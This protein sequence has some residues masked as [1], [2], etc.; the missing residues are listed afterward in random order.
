M[1]N[2][3]TISLNFDKF[4]KQYYISFDFYKGLNKVCKAL[5]IKQ[6]YK[7]ETYSGFK[8]KMTFEQLY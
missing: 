6:I 3:V 2:Y 7:N 1:Y 8:L 5:S 4:S